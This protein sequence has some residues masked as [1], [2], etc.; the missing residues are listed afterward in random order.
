M[1]TQVISIRWTYLADSPSH[2]QNLSWSHYALALVA[3]RGEAGETRNFPG[4]E[5]V[6]VKVFVSR[7]VHV[8][9]NESF[10][11]TKKKKRIETNPLLQPFAL[12]VPP[13]AAAIKQ[14]TACLHFTAWTDVETFLNSC[15][16]E[17]EFLS[18]SAAKAL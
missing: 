5:S 11:Q 8:H 4:I 16:Q 14:P 17:G 10:R 6:L 3:A 12:P 18:A 13:R 1:A 15:E 7:L 9:D 2:L